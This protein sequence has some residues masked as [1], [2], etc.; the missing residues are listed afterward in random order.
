[1]RTSAGTI[2]RATPPPIGWVL[3]TAWKV[4]MEQARRRNRV[5]PPAFRLP[6]TVHL[7]GHALSRPALVSA[8]R[9]LSERQRRVF[10]TRYLFGHDVAETASLL[11]M[12]PQ[13]VKDASREAR[14]R[15]RSALAPYEEDLL[16]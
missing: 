4:S 16:S 12:S 7:D 5:L 11:G 15:L 10:L 2:S 14:D 6:R 3:D 8:M 9:D 13:Q 1:V